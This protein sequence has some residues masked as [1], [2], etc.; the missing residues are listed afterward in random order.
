M[1][2]SKS[3]GSVRLNEEALKA[4]ERR[5][6]EAERKQQE[7]RRRASKNGGGAASSSASIPKT[8]RE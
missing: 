7:R 4:W 6:K 8:R 3:E 1:V 2:E 5:V